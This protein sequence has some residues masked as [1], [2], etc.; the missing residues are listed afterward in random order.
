M[1]EGRSLVTRKVL[2]ATS[3]LRLWWWSLVQFSLHVDHGV[4]HVGQQLSLCS[5]ELLHPCWWW[6]WLPLVVVV[7]WTGHVV[8]LGV[9]AS[10]LTSRWWLIDS[11][12]RPGFHRLIG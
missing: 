3:L 4:G 9:A 10:S 5:E 8:G 12:S 2:V 1:G 11:S 6:W 7:S